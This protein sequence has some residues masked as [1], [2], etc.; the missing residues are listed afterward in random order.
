M[1]N[2]NKIHE[3]QQG[4]TELFVKRSE[5]PI[6]KM[7]I[8]SLEDIDSLDSKSDTEVELALDS[9]RLFE[10]QVDAQMREME[11]NRT[12]CSDSRESSTV[13]SSKSSLLDSDQDS[14]THVS[15]DDSNSFL[16]PT[17]VD[18]KIT[19]VPSD[20][21]DILNSFLLI[22]HQMDSQVD[23]HMVAQTA[24]ST[25]TQV[26]VTREND[27]AQGDI[28]MLRSAL[29]LRDEALAFQDALIEKQR[30]EIAL[31]KMERDLLHADLKSSRLFHRSSICDNFILDRCG[32]TVC[33]WS[34][35]FQA[36]LKCE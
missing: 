25:T 20:E 18:G 4:S 32:R 3:Q 36:V 15:D 17:S 31:L 30:Q 8:P 11:D 19:S 35:S 24:T 6:Q 14:N 1:G 12:K 22:E 33:K 16:E 34:D 5:S 2:S 10:A 13:E 23:S 27:I 29:T 26:I 7:P 28:V 9:F 21:G